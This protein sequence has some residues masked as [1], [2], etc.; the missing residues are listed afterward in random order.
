MARPFV[1]LLCAFRVLNVTLVRSYF[2]PDEFWQTLEPAYCTVF[3]PNDCPGYTWEWKRKTSAPSNLIADSLLG[4]ARTYLNV[5]PTHV[6]YEICKRYGWDS[7]WAIARG[8]MVLA[9]VT[10]GE[11]YAS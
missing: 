9:A 4:P 10:V 3:Y 5:L 1:L 7:S 2:D 8:P 6:Y 11:Q